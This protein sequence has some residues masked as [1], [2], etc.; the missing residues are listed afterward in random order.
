MHRI[1]RVSDKF[2]E[3]LQLEIERND[4]LKASEFSHFAL[5]DKQV[6]DQAEQTY[7]DKLHIALGKDLNEVIMGG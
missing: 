3:I 2:L 7:I 1:M 4:I 5:S 6:Y